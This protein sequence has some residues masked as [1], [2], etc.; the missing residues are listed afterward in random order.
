MSFFD[1]KLFG[2]HVLVTGGTKGLGYA[3]VKTF[4]SAGANVSYCARTVTGAEFDNCEGKTQ[5]CRAVGSVVDISDPASIEQWVTK[6]HKEFGRID[7]V[8]ANATPNLSENTQDAWEQSFRAD[9]LGL[10]A[11]IE[12]TMPYLEIQAASTGNA[13]IVVMSSMAGFE[14]RLPN[15]GS[16]YSAFKR[17]QAVLA[18]DYARIVG[19]KNIRIN[20]IV[21]GAVETPGRILPDGTTEP[22]TFQVVRQQDP[23][24][25]KRLLETNAL[26]RVGKPEDVANAAI[27][28]SS[29]LSSYTTGA[30]LVL[31]GGMSIFF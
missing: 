16:P 31:D 10:R 9:V 14:R 5:G 4:L 24:F 22:S 3:I 7:H 8:I 12:A 25:F 26:G 1:P 29:P 23:E 17:A 2:T 19:P 18:K 13:S 28:L 21:P 6:A 20:V 27:F 30:Y 15:M 11:L